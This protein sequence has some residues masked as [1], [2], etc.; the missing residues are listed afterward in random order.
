MYAVLL[1]CFTTGMLSRNLKRFYII[2]CNQSETQYRVLKLDRSDH[3]TLDV[4]EDGAIYTKGELADL[5][6]MIENANKSTGGLLCPIPLFYG[7]AGMFAHALVKSKAECLTRLYTL[8]GWLVRCPDQK[9][10]SGRIDRRSLC[11]SLRRNCDC[12]YRCETR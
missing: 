1:L 10:F 3:Q 11:L 4:V 2:G 8:H 5:M 9:T 6:A 12:A 7:I